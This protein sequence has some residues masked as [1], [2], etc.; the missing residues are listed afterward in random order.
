MYPSRVTGYQDPLSLK[1]FFSHTSVNLSS[2]INLVAKV[3]IFIKL[4]MYVISHGCLLNSYKAFFHLHTWFF[5]SCVSTMTSYKCLFIVYGFFSWEALC[6]KSCLVSHNVSIYCMMELWTFLHVLILHP[7]H[8]SSWTVFPFFLVSFSWME[9][10]T[11]MMSLYS[12]S[13]TVV[14]C[15][16]EQVFILLSL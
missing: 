14:T 10:C 9:G 4:I 15:S 16:S 11:S 8:H 2:F 1:A 7:R 12:S 13:W 6:Y 5:L 3:K